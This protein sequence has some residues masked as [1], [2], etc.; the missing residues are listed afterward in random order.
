MGPQSKLEIHMRLLLS[1]PL[2]CLFVSVA[3]LASAQ[4]PEAATVGIA[5]NMASN[6]VNQVIDHAGATANGVVIRAGSDVDAEINNFRAAYADM[7]NKTVSSLDST[8]TKQLSQIFS[9]S[10]ALENKTAADAKRIVQLAQQT[11]NTIPFSKTA[12]QLTSAEPT[13][14]IYSPDLLSDVQ[15]ELQGNFFDVNA[16]DMAPYAVLNGKHIPPVHVTTQHLIF[17][18][19]RKTLAISPGKVTSLAEIP[20]TVPYKDG[21]IFKTRKETTFLIH[22]VGIPNN[23]GR[24]TLKVQT[25]I[26]TVASIHVR[27]PQDNQQSDRDDH[28]DQHCGPNET[29][30]INPNSVKLVFEH[31]EGGTWT[32]HPTRLNNPSVCYWFRTEHHGMGTSDKLWWHYEYDVSHTSN[33]IQVSQ[34]DVKLKWGDS[35]SFPVAAGQ[36]TVIYDSFDGSH[37][38]FL[39]GD[40]SNRFIDI[41]TQGGGLLIAARPVDGIIDSNQ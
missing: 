8:A 11:S 39:A 5:L 36:F 41:S 9:D 12:P 16:G 18:L 20:V 4:I 25:P 21:W 23:P 27:T 33:S 13:Y 3:P 14:D 10:S 26:T 30:P 6:H 29:D 38:E 34:Q 28:E 22:M 7:L 35:L 37:H 2:A 17:M 15:L 24:I 19:P 31:T 1:I 40:H 32:D